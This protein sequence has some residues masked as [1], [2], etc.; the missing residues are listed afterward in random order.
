MDPAQVVAWGIVID[1]N[2]RLRALCV[3][4]HPFL[5]DHFAR[6][7]ADLGIETEPAVGLDAA[8]AASRIFHPEVIIC[9]YEVLATLPLEAW[10]K[11]ELLCRMPVIAI[12]LTR[13][14]HE[15]HLLDVNG[16]GGFLYLPSL[17]PE[18]AMRIIAA[19]AT[20]TRNRY[21]PSPAFTSMIHEAEPAV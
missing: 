17:D 18:S 16:I 14:P 2:L 7:F 19:A 21:V 9:E 12:S 6:F 11:D 10:E 13:R 1:P 4:R 5:S 15:A 20:A 8:L 3:G